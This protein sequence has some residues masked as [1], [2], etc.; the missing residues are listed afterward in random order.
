MKT[1]SLTI[2]ALLFV[3]SLSHGQTLNIEMDSDSDSPYLLGK[4]DKNGLTSEHYNSWFSKNYEDYKLNETTIKKIKSTL[5]NYQIT[6]F[7]GTWCGDS[8]REVPRF[9]KILEACNFPMDQ[10]SVIAVSSKSNRYK[11]SPEHEEQGL[12]IHRVP[13][14]IFYKNEQKINRIVEYPVESLEKD[15]LNIIRTNN[16]KSQ[17]QIVA[18]INT[19]L[20]NKGLKGFKKQKNQLLKTYKDSVTSMF[21]LN[22]Y[23]RV[24]YSANRTKE[25]I[26]VFKLNTKLFPDNPRTFMSLANTLGISGDSKK[27]IKVIE[28]AIKLFPDHE[29]LVENLETLK[30]R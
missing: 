19:I 12:N 6:L 29:D 4:I 26:E 15:I 1:I 20:E 8:K 27:A 18:K 7:L 25:A 5:K 9:Y 16:Y 24:L 22:T 2:L 3:L 21:E 23:A 10:L 17:Y 14:F 11:Q 30:S 13:T 28:N